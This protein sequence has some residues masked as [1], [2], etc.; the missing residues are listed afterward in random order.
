MMAEATV[1]RDQERG[2]EEQCEGVGG[3][4]MQKQEELK[5]QESQ[6]RGI[7]QSKD[8]WKCER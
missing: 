3:R 5:E 4:T 2:K 7:Q 6:T 8:V 1:E